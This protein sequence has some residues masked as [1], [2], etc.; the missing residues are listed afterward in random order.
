[1]VLERSTSIRGVVELSNTIVTHYEIN[2]SK[3]L[4]LITDGGGDRKVI[5]LSVQTALIALMDEII[6]CRPAFGLSYRNPV[7]RVHSIANIGLQSVGLM[8]QA[9][10]PDK[11]RLI[12]N[13]NSNAEIRKACEGNEEL[14]K[15]LAESIKVP[16]QF[17]SNIFS[18]L[19]LKGNKFNIIEPAFEDEVTEFDEILLKIF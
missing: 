12:K 15:V 10:H 14:E 17:L 18:E 9:V 7:E 8:R 1:M 6:A 2:I 11:E 13:L 16:T 19:F 3:N 4:Y 5:N